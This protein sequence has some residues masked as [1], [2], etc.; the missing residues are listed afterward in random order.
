LRIGH[1]Q[2]DADCLRT[3]GGHGYRLAGL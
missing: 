3:V 1:R 2:G